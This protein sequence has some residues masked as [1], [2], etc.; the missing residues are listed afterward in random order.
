MRRHTV[1]LA[2]LLV[3]ALVVCID[4][5]PVQDLGFLTAARNAIG[6]PANLAAVRTLLVTGRE[7]HRNQW[8]APGARNNEFVGYAFETRVL[9]PEHYLHRMEADSGNHIVR[10]VGFAGPA[11]LNRVDLPPG[12]QGESHYPADQLERERESLG[13]LSLLLFLKTDSAYHF[14]FRSGS[15]TTL[16]F[17][18]SDGTDVFI[19]LDTSTHRPQT[20]RRDL[21]QTDGKVVHVAVAIAEYST[22]DEL[23]VPHL[24][25]WTRDGAFDTERRL[26]RFVINPSLT[27]DDFKRK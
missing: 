6:G 19:D 4:G 21:R 14:E 2:I 1:T 24:L 26:V 23:I 22:V 13:Y 20:L 17:R 10:Y 16:A 5:R 27:V 11:L 3:A 8:F 12:A 15:N 9:F 18:A 25:T 7:K